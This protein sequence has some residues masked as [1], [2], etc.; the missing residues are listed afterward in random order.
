MVEPGAQAKGQKVIE[1]SGQA[2]KDA[3]GSEINTRYNRPVEEEMAGNT[4]QPWEFRDFRHRE[5]LTYEQQVAEVRT[6]C[7]WYLENQEYIK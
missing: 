4:N 6:L 1:A 7:K 2:L 5:S 3:R